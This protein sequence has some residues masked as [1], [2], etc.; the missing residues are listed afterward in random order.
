MS[1]QDVE[2]RLQH[3]I[4]RHIAK[5]QVHNI[6]VGVQSTDGRIDAAAAAGHADPAGL[7]AMTPDTPFYL[8]S[9]T[10]M[11][12]ATVI[13]TL[14]R[15]GQIDLDSPISAYLSAELIK[16]IHIIDGTNHSDRIT[17][18]RLLD[19]TSGLADYFGGKT[20]SGQSLEEE[21]KEGRDR[22]LS[23]E[24]IMDIVRG[25]R[26]EFAPGAGDGRRA[27]YSDTNYALLGAII[28][29]ITDQSV[30]DNFHDLIF[31]PLELASTYVF[32]HSQVQPPPAAMYFKTRPVE[33][34]LAMSSFAPDG[35]VVST[36]AESLRFLR[37][38]F[39]GELLTEDELKI[40]T[41]RWNRIFFPIQYGRGLMRYKLPRWM[42]PFVAPPELIG[43]SGSTGSFAFHDPGRG[44]Y[45]AGTVNQMD[46]PARPFRLMT[47]L[48]NILD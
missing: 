14:A 41:R 42:S 20:K 39:G 2:I 30:A 8:A 43:H 29:S 17:V 3:L 32:D 16:D 11:F 23:I 38:F 45:L 28:E 36:L 48:I 15:L 47:Q 10:K 5:G 34:P 46:N 27:S 40:M 13:M 18:A 35:G 1:H 21:L 31:A 22:A 26:P 7:T 44:V 37:G 33:I 6:V 24:T 12:T 4:D 25:L 9:I 19:Q